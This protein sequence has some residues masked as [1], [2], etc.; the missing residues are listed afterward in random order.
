MGRRL[1]DALDDSTFSKE[2]AMS[3]TFPS[4]GAK[5]SA[6]RAEGGMGGEGL[7]SD[8]VSVIRPEPLMMSK[9]S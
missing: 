7:R 6:V 1:T 9:C 5:S 8:T 4:K 2:L 3:A